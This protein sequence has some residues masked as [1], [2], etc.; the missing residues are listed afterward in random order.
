MQGRMGI[1][2]RGLGY[3]GWWGFS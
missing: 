1:T 2:H 3:F